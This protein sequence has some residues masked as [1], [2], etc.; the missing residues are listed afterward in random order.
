MAMGR[1]G[2]REAELATMAAA[3]CHDKATLADLCRSA[4]RYAA[5]V[6]HNRKARNRAR[7]ATPWP[8][9]VGS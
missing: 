4:L 2:R 9:R 6:F 8:R 5:A 1:V 3:F 7:E